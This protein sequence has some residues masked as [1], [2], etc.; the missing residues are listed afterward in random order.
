MSQ[1]LTVAVAGANG[2]VGSHIVRELVSRGHSVR[3]LVRDLAAARGMFRDLPPGSVKLVAGHLED[4]ASLRELTAGCRACVNAVGILRESVWGGQTFRRVHVGGVR[5]LIEA[6]RDAGVERFV[7]ISA[8]GVGDEGAT[9]YQRTKFKGEMLVRR[10]GLTWTILRPGIIVGAGGFLSM[11]AD[12]ARGEKAPWYFLPYFQR[13]EYGEGR[14]PLEPVRYVDPL[15]QPVRVEDVAWAVGESLER[16]EAA[17]EVYNLVGPDVMT[18]PELLATVRDA[19][20]GHWNI[21][22]MGI[23]ADKAAGVAKAARFL[24]LG[25]SLPFDEGMAAMGATDSVADSVKARELLGFNP[26]PVLPAIGQYAGRL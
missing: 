5:N 3:G 14:I 2:F 20:P 21:Q 24:G 15:V 22:P 12:W 17:G 4:G 19:V 13:K 16:P 18:W 6:S 1:R 26:R 23:P 9:E 25:S 10:S 8:L 11:V 7:Q